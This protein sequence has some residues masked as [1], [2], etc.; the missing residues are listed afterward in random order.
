[1]KF[2]ARTIQILRNF[3]TINP[4][5]VFKEGNEL[6]TIA[7]P[8]R[9][10]LARATIDTQVPSAFAIYDLSKFLSAIS[11]FEEP[12]LVPTGQKAVI[13]SGGE[14]INWTLAEPSLILSP[15]DR[16]LGVVEPDVKFTLKNDILSRTIKALSIIGVPEIAVTGEDGK[17]H[18]EALNTK[19]SSESSY[20][21]QVGET[22][23]T[24]RLIFLAEN[25]KLLPGDYEVVISKRGIAH[26]KS[27]DLEYWITIEQN[28]TFTD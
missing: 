24:F 11:M 3:S 27:E 9:A 20:R 7:Y 13:T 19:N 15:P 10:V 16:G 21:V 22:D 2:S 8:S 23:K 18:I 12:D 28:S 26:F 6:R 14:R 17:I 25:I 4:S 1:M 5:L